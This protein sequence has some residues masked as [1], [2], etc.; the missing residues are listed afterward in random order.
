MK[1]KG[2]GKMAVIRCP[3]CRGTGKDPGDSV[4]D[5]TTSIF[6]LITLGI[7]EKDC[8]LCHGTGYIRDE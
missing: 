8:K 3:R 5:N 2:G 6:S 7:F 4:L 1:I